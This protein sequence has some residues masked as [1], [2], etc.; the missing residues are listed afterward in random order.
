MN[1]NIRALLIRNGIKHKE[2]AAEIGVSRVAVSGVVAGH[3]QSERIQRHI[4]ARLG[5]DYQKLWGKAA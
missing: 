5:K 3:W 1:R 4:A 2:L